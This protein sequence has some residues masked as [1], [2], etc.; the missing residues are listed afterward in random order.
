[1]S[2]YPSSLI[3]TGAALCGVL[4]L[5]CNNDPAA[6]KTKVEAVAP[7]QETQAATPAPASAVELK[8]TPEAGSIDFVGAKITDKHQG[9]FKNFS[10]V[11]HYVDGHI[12]K[13]DVSVSIDINSLQVDP[14]KLRGH[15]LSADFF[16][17]EKFPKATFTSTSI[18]AKA[19]GNTSHEITGN[20]ELHGVK[21]SITFP[22]SIST[23]G[24]GLVIVAEFAI[25]R[26]DFNI[27]YPGKPDDLIKDDVLIKLKF[28][29]T[30]G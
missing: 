10:G 24:M 13:S 16:D 28:N 5:G 18:V 23:G 19:A 3:V 8:L 27:V 4:A 6:G 2:R 12:D 11:V 15:L 7:V 14:E 26:K 21:K 30:R 22:A 9:S 29:P 25:N 1:M 20:L 17:V